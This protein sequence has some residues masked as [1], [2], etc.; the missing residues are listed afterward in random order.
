V[1]PPEASSILWCRRRGARRCGTILPGHRPVCGR[2]ADSVFPP[3]AHCRS[4]RV[5]VTSQR[6]PE[7]ALAPPKNSPGYQGEIGGHCILEPCE[8]DEG[9]AGWQRRGDAELFHAASRRLYLCDDDARSQSADHAPRCP[10]RMRYEADA[11]APAAPRDAGTCAEPPAHAA[12]PTTTKGSG[13]AG[14]NTPQR[15]G[16]C[17]RGCSASGFDVAR[18]LV[19]VGR[20]ARA[21]LWAGR[22]RPTAAPFARASSGPPRRRSPIRR[23]RENH[24]RTAPRS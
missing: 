12:S 17:G 6:G 24:E 9:C 4:G 3:L 14:P 7:C 22:G 1:Q 15:P 23:S 10:S 19:R 18:R 20:S 21:I 11:P 2:H 5:P 8:T 13:A 16:G